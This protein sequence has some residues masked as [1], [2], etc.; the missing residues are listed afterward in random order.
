MKL[1]PEEQIDWRGQRASK[2]VLRGQQGNTDGFGG[3]WRCVEDSLRMRPPSA[4][5]RSVC[6]CVSLYAC[7]CGGVCGMKRSESSCLLIM[8]AEKPKNNN[9]Q[10]IMWKSATYTDYTVQGEVGR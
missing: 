3:E 2:V 9:N 6:V 7:A 10:R 5:M 1:G 4:E 8:K